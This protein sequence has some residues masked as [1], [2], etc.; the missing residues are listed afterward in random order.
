MSA[1]V[2][3]VASFVESPDDFEE[4]KRI[5]GR[6]TPAEALVTAN[7]RVPHECIFVG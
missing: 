4:F 5:F 3:D 1:D 6:F 7:V 2:T